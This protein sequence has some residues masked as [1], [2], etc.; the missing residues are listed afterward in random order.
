MHYMCVKVLNIPFGYRKQIQVYIYMYKNV[1][2]TVC[3]EQLE[4]KVFQDR[5]QESK[6]SLWRDSYIYFFPLIL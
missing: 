1:N 4:R 5:V 6:L 2:D 3:F